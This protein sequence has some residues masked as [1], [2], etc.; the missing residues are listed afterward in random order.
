MHILNKFQAHAMKNEESG[1]FYLVHILKFI[2][3]LAIKV[4]V[5]DS[6]NKNCIKKCIQL[7]VLKIFECEYESEYFNLKFCEYEYE[8]LVFKILEYEYE[9]EYFI[10]KILEYAYESEY[11]K[12]P[13]SNT[14]VF[15]L[16]LVSIKSL[17]IL[18]KIVFYKR[19][20]RL[21]KQS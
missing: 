4:S 20:A 15:V 1:Y 9:S 14:D 8:Y 17:L 11:R 19:L 18:L 5:C 21:A 6:K 16:P 7:F 10:F 12:N 13:Y 3:I 2:L